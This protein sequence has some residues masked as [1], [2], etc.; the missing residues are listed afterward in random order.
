MRVSEKTVYR[1]VT[2]DDLPAEQINGQYRFNRTELLEWATVRKMEVSPV[3]FQQPNDKDGLQPRLDEA[4][5]AGG[6]LY[7]VQGSDKAAVLSDMVQRMP[8]PDEVDRDFVVEVFL[9]RE[10]L[11]STGIGDGLA[12]PHPRYPLVLPVAGPM[13]ILCFLAQAIAYSPTDKQPV[14]T[15]FALISPTVRAH[16]HLLARLAYALRDPTFRDT[17][18]RQGSAEEIL[19]QAR[20]LE[21]TIHQGG[22]HE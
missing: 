21:D 16:L 19:E 12:I 11:G 18:R 10:S 1:W 4:L 9:S 7:G 13:V 5:Q 3:L 14:H 2:D 17:V 20:R 15:L 22:G 6:I 8:L